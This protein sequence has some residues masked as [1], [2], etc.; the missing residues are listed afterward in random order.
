MK[1]TLYLWSACKHNIY[2]VVCYIFNLYFLLTIASKRDLMYLYCVVA[3]VAELV[4]ATDS[5]SVVH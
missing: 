4:D 3:L 5:K 1:D 2:R